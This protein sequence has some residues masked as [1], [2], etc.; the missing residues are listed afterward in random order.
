M[1]DSARVIAGRCTTV[2]EG[3]REQEQHGDM[4]VLT[5]PDGTVLIHDST[6]YQPVAWL[7]RAEAVTV[8]D[9]RITASDGDQ[10]LIVTIHREHTRETPP[11]TDAG[12]PVGACPNCA[13]SLV[14]HSGTVSCPGCGALY[15]LP[16]KTTVLDDCCSA[17]GLPQLRVE[18]GASF[19]VCLD[20]DCDPL[21]E[22]VRG[23]FDREWDCPDC[24]G[25]L[26]VIRRGGLLLGCENYPDC[27]TSFVF[28]AGRHVGTCGC[29]LP[30]FETSNGQRCPDSTCDRPQVGPD[31]D[32]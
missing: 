32:D 25:K 18:R 5:K 17:C 20:R 30:L 11:V 28:P 24:A 29:G 6:G 13:D 31:P 19:D 21:D 14:R 26:R 12:I 16:S 2:F 15:P 7:T 1:P 9:G 23:A 10:Q 4:V 22:H 3:T 8:T 27:E